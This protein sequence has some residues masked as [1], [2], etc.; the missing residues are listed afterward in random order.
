MNNIEIIHSLNKIALELDH[1]GSYRESEEIDK[2][3]RIAIKGAPKLR[4]NHPAAKELR[5]NHLEELPPQNI[6]ESIYQNLTSQPG[7]TLPRIR[8]VSDQDIK[9]TPQKFFYDIQRDFRTNGRISEDFVN[10]LLQS[11]IFS[12]LLHHYLF[13]ET[14][15]S[16][17]KD[18][19][20]QMMEKAEPYLID[21]LEKEFRKHKIIAGEGSR[22][23]DFIDVLEKILKLGEILPLEFKSQVEATKEWVEYQRQQ[24]IQAIHNKYDTF[25]D[26]HRSPERARKELDEYLQYSSGEPSAI[27]RAQQ[28][29]QEE[30]QTLRNSNM[31]NKIYKIANTLDNSGYHKEATSLTNVMKRLAQDYS[32][33]NRR[34]VE[35]EN[36]PNLILNLMFEK[37]WPIVPW[38][39]CEEDNPIHK[40]TGSDKIRFV[41]KRMRDIHSEMVMSEISP[42]IKDLRTIAKILQDIFNQNTYSEFIDRKRVQ[43]KKEKLNNFNDLL[44]QAEESINQDNAEEFWNSLD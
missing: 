25:R 11:S 39:L 19:F 40:F 10:L 14:D 16:N 4:R 24:E 22:D 7:K 44:N 5:D 42:S 15:D 1:N 38:E 20:K 26:D 28:K 18:S 12:F 27:E 17:L 21:K 30:T 23:I 32:D 6:L 41:C 35:E 13:V 31:I 8:L 2:L 29:R 37:L 3:I 9:W 36:Y 33:T 43:I 34:P